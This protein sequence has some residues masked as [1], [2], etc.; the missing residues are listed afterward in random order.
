M[1]FLLTAGLNFSPSLIC[2]PKMEKY[3]IWGVKCTVPSCNATKRA[4][5]YLRFFKFPAQ[6]TD[7]FAKWMNACNLNVPPFTKNAYVCSKH[8]TADCFGKKKLKMNSV[9]SLQLGQNDNITNSAEIENNTPQNEDIIPVLFSGK[10]YEVSQRNDL[11]F[12]D[13]IELEKSCVIKDNEDNG[14][15]YVSTCEQCFQ[16]Q[17]NLQFYKMRYMNLLKKYKKLKSKFQKKSAAVKKT[18]F[19]FK[20]KLEESKHLKKEAKIPLK[21]VIDSLLSINKEAKTL[22]KM[23][24]SSRSKCQKWPE[25][26]KLLAQNLHYKSPACYRY[27]QEYL[28]IGLPS[29]RSINRWLPIK[30]MQPGFNPI[31][32]H[33][34]KELISTWNL[35]VRQ[36]VLVFDEVDIRRSLTFDTTKDEII[37]YVD[38]GN[39]K[40]IELAKHV[41]LFMIRGIFSNWKIVI[42]YFATSNVM[43]SEHLKNKIKDNISYCNEIGINI[44]A[45]VCDQGSNNRSA[46]KLLGT[47]S[48]QPYFY[49]NSKKIFVIYDVPHLF[50]SIRNT[51]IKSDISFEGGVASWKVPEE[52]YNIEKHQS[53][54]MC[55]KL[56]TK[57]IYPNTWQKMKVSYAVQVMSHTCS[58]AIRTVHSLEKFSTSVNSK[59]IST[60]TFFDKLNHAFDCLNSKSPFNRNIYKSAI[61][62]DGIVRSYLE[63]IIP[64]IETFSTQRKNY[65]FDGLILT[66]RSI[67]LLTGELLDNFPQKSYVLLYKFNQDVEENMFS[68]LRSSGGNNQNP[69]LYEFNHLIGKILSIK[70]LSLK[71]KKSNC[72][73]DEEEFIFENGELGNCLLSVAQND[74]DTGSMNFTS[75]CIDERIEVETDNLENYNFDI[76]NHNDRPVEDNSLRYFVGFILHKLDLKYK[77]ELCENCMKRVGET[78]S[79]EDK[80]ELFL[81]H[82]N[83]SSNSDFGKLTAP[84]EY[85][86][87]VMKFNYNIFVKIITTSP[88]IKCLKETIKNKGIALTKE[89]LEFREWFEENNICFQ[90]RINALDYFIEILLKKHCQWETEKI[91]LQ[92]KQANR[93]LNII[94]T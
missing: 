16:S 70:V 27:M 54:K 62:K 45:I 3:K 43:N 91:I 24:T 19:A 64:F 5:P 6:G 31:L 4:S 75:T 36:A 32:T 39:E 93:K 88:N 59:A 2:I 86:F 38:M 79:L 63:V 87:Q 81:F 48:T 69:S 84:T 60:A 7:L 92:K 41:C 9:P 94:N 53:V 1:D 14:D 34:L 40:T 25:D 55:P 80:S 11:S 8:F 90:H 73:D 30:C 74:A 29:I 18:R 50:K 82:K 44:R 20:N 49:F 66:I 46:L 33:N 35:E 15:D 72:E 51:L 61:K 13:L 77:C 65:C 37:G 22:V 12:E 23:V 67:L 68:L 17:K 10:T 56:T 58:S 85:F 26:A 47:N 52:I 89:S 42:S 57:H 71:S 76:I 28:K 78:I 21:N 83:F